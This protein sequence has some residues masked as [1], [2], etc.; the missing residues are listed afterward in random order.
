MTISTISD[1]LDTVGKESFEELQ[2][3]LEEICSEIASKFGLYDKV[4]NPRKAAI[5]EVVASSTCVCCVSRRLSATNSTRI[6]GIYT[7]IHKL[8]TNILI[9]EL[10]DK[11]R[12][13]G[14]SVSILGEAETRFGKVD[15]II[16]P[17]KV[18]IALQCGTNQL[19]VEVKTGFSMSVP[20][21]FR[22]LLDQE[23]RIVVLWRIR[24][25]QVL[26]FDGMQLNALLKRFMKTCILRGQ[27]LLT[28]PQETSCKHRSQTN[29]SPTQE[30]L[31]EMLRDFAT[32][33]IETLPSV[34]KTVFQTLKLK[35]IRN[36]SITPNAD[37]PTVD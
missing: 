27:R 26:S 35:E 4:G 25:R 16:K 23:N 14:Y 15:I 37:K 31:Q 29:W 3:S 7:E 28:S 9:E 1:I 32:G 8:A 36:D 17:T 6:D 11:F 13:S 34:V 33:M 10:Y 18:G 20:Q 24:N 19:I 5:L 30:E 22:Y 12:S 21:I 2:N